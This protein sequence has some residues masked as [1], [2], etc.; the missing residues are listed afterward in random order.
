MGHSPK[1]I[2]N[3]KWSDGYKDDIQ[4]MKSTK[5]KKTE[6]QAWNFKFP[7]PV[8]LRPWQFGACEIYFYVIAGRQTS[9]NQYFLLISMLNNSGRNRT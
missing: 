1:A 6:K 2:S 9:N 5:Q 3:Y 7:V 8:I 4:N